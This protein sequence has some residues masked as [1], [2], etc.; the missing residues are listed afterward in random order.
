[1]SS[2]AAR[3]LQTLFVQLP[4]IFVFSFAYLACRW[5]G[6]RKFG[7]VRGLQWLGATGLVP[8]VLPQVPDWPTAL[9]PDL[10]RPLHAVHTNHFPEGTCR[11]LGGLTDGVEPEK[12]WHRVKSQAQQSASDREAALTAQESSS[13]R[14]GNCACL[15]QLFPTLFSFGLLFSV[16]SHSGF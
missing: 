1:M 3:C 14:K 10:A 2:N 12:C 4:V 13:F 15:S 16:G 7:W 5:I 8:H 6:S 9:H 11:F